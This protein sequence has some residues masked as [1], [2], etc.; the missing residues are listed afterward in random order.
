MI[1]LLFIVIT[2]VYFAVN[3]GFAYGCDVLMG[4]R[5]GGFR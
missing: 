2:V 3:V 1:D 5:S 4:G